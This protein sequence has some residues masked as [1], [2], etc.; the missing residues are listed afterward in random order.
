[1]AEDDRPDNPFFPAALG[2]VNLFLPDA[3]LVAAPPA[4][5][6]DPAAIAGFLQVGAHPH[7]HAVHNINNGAAQALTVPPDEHDVEDDDG[8]SDASSDV[9]ELGNED[10]PRYFDERAGRLFH[11][12]GI[13]SSYSF[14]VDGTEWKVHSL[15][16]PRDT[17][18]TDVRS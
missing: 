15:L 14:P 3:A 4:F 11:S 1:M 8:A 10:F 5:M 7:V 12:H 17:R 18:H 9:T 13:S 16:D 2:A 6:T